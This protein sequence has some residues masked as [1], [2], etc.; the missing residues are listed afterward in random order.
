MDVN[1]CPFD[2]SP[3]GLPEIGEARRALCESLLPEIR[4]VAWDLG[5]A[6]AVHGSMRRDLD[7]IAYPWID[8]AAASAT[9]VRV[10]AEALGVP[11]DPP[12]IAP[13]DLKVRPRPHGREPWVIHLSSEFGDGPYLDIAIP[14]RV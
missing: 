12:F 4:R 9:F 8:T 11:P 2:F 13:H 14:P 7:L 5:F 6:V 10:L 1:A 3:H